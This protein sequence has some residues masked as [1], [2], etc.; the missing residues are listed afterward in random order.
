MGQRPQTAVSTIQ[1]L[2][3][4]GNSLL[5][6]DLQSIIYLLHFLLVAVLPGE[7]KA[8]GRPHKSLPIPKGSLQKGW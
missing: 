3:E 5:G 7:Q 2:A 4:C 6:S 1:A 8:L